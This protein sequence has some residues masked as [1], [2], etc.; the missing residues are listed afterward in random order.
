MRT[1]NRPMFRKGGM[2]NQGSGILSHVEPK[3]LSGYR[4]IPKMPLQHLGYAD[5][6]RIIQSF[7]REFNEDDLET[8]LKT[9]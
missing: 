7:D 3:P 8:Y 1:Y 5:G 4:P 9:L 2:T 6:G